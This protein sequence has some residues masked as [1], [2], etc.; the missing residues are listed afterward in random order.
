MSLEEY[1]LSQIKAWS[2]AHPIARW[3]YPALILITAVLSLTSPLFESGLCWLYIG[4]LALILYAFRPKS[5]IHRHTVAGSGRAMTVC[6]LLTALATMAACVL[7]M[8]ALPIWNGEDPDHRNQYELMADAILE[9][10]IE[11]AYGD[12]DNLSGLKNPYDPYERWGAGVWYHWDHAFYKGHYYM[13]FGIVPVLLLFIPYRLLTGEPLTTYHATQVFAIFIIAGFFLLF[14]LL[15]ERFFKKMPC[16]VY[17]WL[18]VAVSVMSVWYATAEPA[19]YCTATTS[20]LA[21]EIWSL[22]FFIKAVY[23]PA[24]EN[25][26]IALAGVGAVFGA[27]AFGCRPSIALANILVLPLLAVFLR[28]RKFTLKLFGKLLLAALPYAIV[29]AGLMT[30]NYVRFENPFEFGQAYQL[31]AADQ[32]NYRF[33]LDPQTLWRIVSGTAAS[34]FRPPRVSGEFPYIAPEGQVGSGPYGVFFNFPILLL[35][36]AALSKASRRELRETRLS[37]L[38][39]GIAVTVLVISAVDVM[40]TP[41]LNERYH[42]DIYFLLGLSL[43]IALGSRYVSEGPNTG[44]LNSAVSAMSLLTVV[45][46][47]LFVAYRVG[48]SYPEKLQALGEFLGLL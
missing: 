32:T 35:G 8:K 11:F 1:M 6:T 25:K 41:F 2:A 16:S 13:Y 31:T 9:G 23:V 21:M 26:Q 17:L 5:E 44:R 37:P 15:A 46:S 24:G 40:W 45:M 36:L 4:G 30:Y 42:M 28:E 33:S 12:E 27:L 20:A 10:R 38:M 34:F 29:A 22:Y 14:R 43:F 39:I 7:P 18:S 19:L 47:F 48:F 3:V